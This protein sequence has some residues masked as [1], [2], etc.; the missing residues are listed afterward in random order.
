MGR[1]WLRLIAGLCGQY[2]RAT[3]Q[4]LY[5]LMLHAETSAVFMPELLHNI[6]R[7]VSK[8]EEDILRNNRV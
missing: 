6:E 4:G 2:I 5:Y 7:L 3:I 1:G 8:T